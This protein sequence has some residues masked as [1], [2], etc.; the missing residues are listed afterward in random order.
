MELWLRREKRLL[1]LAR[2]GLRANTV[3]DHVD[4]QEAVFRQ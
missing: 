2:D 1:L 3:G 4:Q